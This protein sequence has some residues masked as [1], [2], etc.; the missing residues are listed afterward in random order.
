MADAGGNHHEMP[1]HMRELELLSGIEE[2]S[3]DI[4]ACACNKEPEAGCG[5][6]CMEPS[7][8]EEDKKGLVFDVVQTGYTPRPRPPPIRLKHVGVN[9]PSIAKYTMI[10]SSFLNILL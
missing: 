7:D 1:Y 6:S 5:S 3:G 8:T 4:G 9:T 2:Q 10:W